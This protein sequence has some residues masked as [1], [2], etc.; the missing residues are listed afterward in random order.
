LSTWQSAPTIIS[1]VA[2]KETRIKIKKYEGY[3]SNVP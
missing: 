2:L 3:N 1:D